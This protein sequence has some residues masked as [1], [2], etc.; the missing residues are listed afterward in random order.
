V[1][2]IELGQEMSEKRLPW[3]NVGVL[4]DVQLV[5]FQR[6]TALEKDDV[7]AV[8]AFAA[9]QE[10]DSRSVGPLTVWRAQAVPFQCSASAPEVVP[11]K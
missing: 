8:H 3:G 1:Q 5:P 2:E 11:S 7:V 6:I 10:T 9:L 4:C